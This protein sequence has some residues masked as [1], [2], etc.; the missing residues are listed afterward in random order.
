MKNK[1]KKL[2]LYKLARSVYI[3]FKKHREFAG[4][5]QKTKDDKNV[6]IIINPDED[7]IEQVAVLS[8]E[9]IHLFV[10]KDYIRVNPD[11]EEYIADKFRDLMRKGIK[12]ITAEDKI[13]KKGRRRAV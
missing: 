3:G 11:K 6:Y 8:H 5:L 1:M 13:T 10:L 4:Y 9:L 2:S 12:V 7:I